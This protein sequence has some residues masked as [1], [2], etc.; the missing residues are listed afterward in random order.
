M[1]IFTSIGLAVGATVAASA[2]GIGAFGTGVALA[3]LA[4]T[5]LA[6]AGISAFG[7]YAQGQAQKSEMKYQSDV[8]NRQAEMAERAGA[9]NVR[10]TQYQASQDTQALN[11]KYAVL[12]G[13]QKAAFGSEIGGGSVTEGDV[14]TDTFNTQTRDEEMIRYNADLKSWAIK[15]QAGGEVWGLKSQAN[16]FT[17]AGKNAARAGM[18]SGTG[19]IFSGVGN[20]AMTGAMLLK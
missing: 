5:S 6:G 16:Q 20:T 8:A 9:Q 10:L 4:A 19:T 7:Q 18:I 17:Y 2:T 3:G 12:R 1:P 15:E 13:A 11:R 14:A